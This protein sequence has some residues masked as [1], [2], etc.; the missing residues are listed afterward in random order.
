MQMFVFYK[1]AETNGN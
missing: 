1:L